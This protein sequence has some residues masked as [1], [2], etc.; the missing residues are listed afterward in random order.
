MQRLEMRNTFTPTDAP[1]VCGNCD[2]ILNRDL[3]RQET[4]SDLSVLD[5]KTIS[6]SPKWTNSAREKQ[7]SRVSAKTNKP[8]ATKPRM[9]KQSR[10]KQPDKVQDFMRYTKYMSQKEKIEYLKI[11]ED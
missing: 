3:M 2:P 11:S 4:V 10:T 5:L 8:R 7:N 6:N 1:R 9:T